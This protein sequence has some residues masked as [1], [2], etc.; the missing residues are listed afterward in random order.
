[1][2]RI[3]EAAA[4]D[5]LPAACEVLEADDGG[6]AVELLRAELGA[7]RGVDFVLMDFTMVVHLPYPI[8]IEER[9]V[10]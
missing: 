10:T 2:R 3:L 6:R 1:V 8:M 4:G 9:E 7:G 5:G